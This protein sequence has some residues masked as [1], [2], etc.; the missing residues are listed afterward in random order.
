MI[1]VGFEPRITA[2]A[3]LKGDGIFFYRDRGFSDEGSDGF[4][5]LGAITGRVGWTGVFA[6]M[7]GRET[8]AAGRIGYAEMA[9]GQSVETE[10][11]MVET[12]VQVILGTGGEGV[13]I[14]GMIKARRLNLDAHIGR[15][16]CGDFFDA[17]DGSF[18][19][20]HGIVRK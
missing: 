16:G 17:F 5:T 3:G 20:G 15:D 13:D 19:T 11:Q 7:G 18:E 4:E 12:L 1:G 9:L 10:E 8:V 2:K 6:A 14:I